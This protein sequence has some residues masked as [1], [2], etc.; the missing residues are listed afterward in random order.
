MH[1]SALIG[2]VLKQQTTGPFNQEDVYV[3]AEEQTESEACSHSFKLWFFSVTC[4]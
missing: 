2:S 4:E 3:D 1:V